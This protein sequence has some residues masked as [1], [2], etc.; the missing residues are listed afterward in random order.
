[1]PLIGQL[2]LAL[3]LMVAVYSIGANLL[4][5]RRNSPDLLLSARHALWAMCAMVT[6]AVVALWT[7]LLTS[8]FSLEYVA[9]Y[10]SVT[11]PIPYKFTALWGGQQGSLL[12]WTWLLVDIHFDSGV[13]EPPAQSGNHAVGAGRCWPES[14]SFFSEC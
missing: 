5:I 4:G 6:V 8:D 14:R 7:G 11:L 13:P 2:A 10:S 9:S 12:F 3:A 1:M